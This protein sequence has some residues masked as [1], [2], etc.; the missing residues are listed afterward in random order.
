M[1]ARRDAE[2]GQAG[3]EALGVARQVRVRDLLL[4]GQE[5]GPTAEVARPQAEATA[6]EKSTSVGAG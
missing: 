6:P 1:R 3:G 4:G 2:A 5:C